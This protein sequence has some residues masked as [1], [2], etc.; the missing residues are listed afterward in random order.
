[1]HRSFKALQDEA[2]KLSGR[3]ESSKPPVTILHGICQSRYILDIVS[4]SLERILFQEHHAD[5]KRN[6]TDRHRYSQN[7]TPGLPVRNDNVDGK[8][9]EL[10]LPFGNQC[11]GFG[12]AVARFFA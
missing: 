4:V 10:V 12:K 6:G 11:S 9:T 1:M 8:K 3:R 5:R 7:M 2:R